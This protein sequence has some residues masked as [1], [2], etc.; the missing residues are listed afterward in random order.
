MLKEAFDID[1]IPTE[2]YSITEA[3]QAYDGAKIVLDVATR[4]IQKSG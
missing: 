1:F 3:Q 2:E 4:A